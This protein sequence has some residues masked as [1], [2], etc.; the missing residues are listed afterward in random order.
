MEKKSNIFNDIKQKTLNSTFYIYVK[1][2]FNGKL[3]FKGS[4]QKPFYRISVELKIF[5]NIARVQRI[6]WK[7]ISLEF[8]IYQKVSTSMNRAQSQKLQRLC[9]GTLTEGTFKF[10]ELF[11]FVA[12]AARRGSPT[13][14]T[15]NVASV[16]QPTS[17]GRR[18]PLA[19]G[20]RTCTFCGK[21]G[22]S[23]NRCFQKFLI[24]LLLMKLSL[25]I[26][27]LFIYK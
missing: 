5:T 3:E 8:V 11:R 13:D 26:I 18:R 10:Y 17:E 22:Q 12:R 19:G 6:I 25:K 2:N 16:S 4:P 27:Q 14:I 7:M 23:V 15:Y 9:E 20:S 1:N 24:D 21:M